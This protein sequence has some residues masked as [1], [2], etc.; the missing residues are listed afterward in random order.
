M[1]SNF[2]V[3]TDSGQV[4]FVARGA[5]QSATNTL[6]PLVCLH[7]TPSSGLFFVDFLNEAS[8]HRW[9]LAPDTPGF[10]NSFR[11]GKPPT[12]SDY[13]DWLAEALDKVDG[14]QDGFDLLGFH[15]GCFIAVEAAISHGGVRNLVLP[16]I[17]YF[18]EADRPRHLE[19]TAKPPAYLAEPAA[20]GELWAKKASGLPANVA[21]EDYFAIWVEE[22]RSA[23]N[24]WWGFRAVFTYDADPRLGALTQ[25]TLAIADAGLNA[26]TKEAAALIPNAELWD[27]PE[28]R[29]PLFSAHVPELIAALTDW[30]SAESV[31][32]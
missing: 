23:P 6:R 30:C 21:A 7:P 12:I 3:S 29:S 28:W 1:T 8:D 32:N 24:G 9:V 26:P 13:G 2:Y 16:G 11:P 14:L 31:R 17:P 22:L 5:S 20:L 27:R 4:H 25:R 15:T 10:G 19:A 18:S